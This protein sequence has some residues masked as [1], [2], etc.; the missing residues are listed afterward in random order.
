MYEGDSNIYCTVLYMYFCALFILPVCILLSLLCSLSSRHTYEA[1]LYVSAQVIIFM[2]LI[3]I[4]NKS[5]NRYLSY[6]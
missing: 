4:S 6:E 2:Q 3:N 1:F 5:Y